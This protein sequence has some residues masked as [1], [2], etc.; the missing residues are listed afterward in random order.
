MSI[1]NLL[2]LIPE[3]GSFLLRDARDLRSV[4][5]EDA[6]GLPL[7]QRI[8]LDDEEA[9]PLQGFPVLLS[10]PLRALRKALE[11]YV[12]AEEEV[13][14][15][16]IMGRQLEKRPAEIAW[17][18]YRSILVPCLTNAV[19]SS[20][21]RGYP[22]IFWLYHSIAV[23]RLFKEI[24]KH[25]IITKAEV[26]RKYGGDIKY[27]IFNR[28][29]DKALDEMY[30]IVE[31]AA[32]ETEEMED[33]LFPQI[34]SRMRDNVLIL[35]EDHIGPDLRE[36]DGFFK[37]CL[38]LD[39]PV[40]RKRLTKLHAWHIERLGSA[41]FRAQIRSLLE[42]D[43]IGNPWS[44]IVRQGYVPFL[45]R[46][47]SYKTSELLDEEQ[48]GLWNQL[49]HRLKEYELL[50]TLRRYVVPVH[51]VGDK[52]VCPGSAFRGARRSG[53]ATVLSYTTRPLDY[54]TPWV[55]DPLV[56]R[57][58]LIY[59]ITDFSSVVSLLRRSGNEAQ[60]L[61][62]RRIFSFQRKV[63]TIARGYRLQLEKYLGDGALYSGR[64]PSLLLAAA[65][66][67]QRHYKQV[68]SEDFPFDRGMRLALNFG[69]YRLLPIE[70]GGPAGQHRYEFFG[71][72]IVELSRLVSGKSRQEF[73]EIKN[74]LVNYGYDPMEVERFFEPVTRKHDTLVD[75]LDDRRTFFAA[76]NATGTL[77][78]E[79]IV[80]THY[81]MVQAVRD[82]A[83]HLRG[84]CQEG[85]R[86]YVVLG[87]DD[88]PDHLLVGARMLGKARLK[89]LDNAHVL[90]IVDGAEW[91]ESD[92]I[93]NQER[94]L[95]MSPRRL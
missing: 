34:L 44:L 7:P 54:S 41:D 18:N 19:S 68:V 88:D 16:V 73:E 15:S 10:E 5:G 43:E 37:A 20:F 92:L 69:Q 53:E 59:D 80:A 55:V 6:E 32:K 3:S 93:P 29:L 25:I 86:R 57:Y 77:V 11:V 70:G 81:F 52:F 71:H 95:L 26:G 39:G 2:R 67:L 40:F 8:F 1:S 47:D 22:S 74:Q 65:V 82:E 28:Y 61:S 63:N 64:H 87:I 84:L 30:Q 76:L 46:L 17:D 36:L 42:L 9:T 21:G 23:S 66:R 31:G 35:T 90:E 62:F 91:K 50:A 12:R 79:G 49:L 60:D 33:E 48:I 94:D 83:I 38:R 24:P 85:S 27:R 4:V 89:G 14:L 13:E 45:S 75:R 78:N 72:G 51:E 58:G 56:R